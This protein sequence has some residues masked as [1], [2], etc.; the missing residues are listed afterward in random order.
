M[1]CFFFF[2][3]FFKKFV[4]LFVC[5]HS[6]FL[7]CVWIFCFTLRKI[8][9]HYLVLWIQWGEFNCHFF[10]KS[11]SLLF[12]DRHPFSITSAPGDLFLSVH[13]RTSGDWTNEMKRIFSEVS[14]RGYVCWLILVW[15]PELVLEWSIFLRFSRQSSHKNASLLEGDLFPWTVLGFRV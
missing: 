9:S 13:I 5:F 12:L 4:C 3:H 2:F 11:L 14:K 10:L 7:V 6:W 1:N 15:F 8:N